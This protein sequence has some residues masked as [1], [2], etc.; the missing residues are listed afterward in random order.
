[1]NDELLSED[2]MLLLDKLYKLRNQII[3]LIEALDRQE[4]GEFKLGTG[5]EKFDDELNDFAILLGKR[6]T[7]VLQLMAAKENEFEPT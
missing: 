3:D 4:W 1:M 7:N 5:L 6:I 2:Y